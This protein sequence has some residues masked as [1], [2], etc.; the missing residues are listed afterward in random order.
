MTTNL[1]KV[2]DYLLLIDKEAEIKKG[3]YRIMIDKTSILYG[4]FEKH[5]GN[6]EC[7]EQWCK[8]IAYYPLIKGA[9]ELEGLPKLPNPFEEVDIEELAL[10]AY[11]IDS[12]ETLD[13]PPFENV[14]NCI[15]GFIEGYKA[16]QSKGQ[17]SL[18]DMKKAFNA[19]YDLNTWEQLEIP[20][21]ER[22]Y[23]NEDEYIQSLSTQQLPKEFIPEYELGYIHTENGFHIPVV[24]KEPRLKTITNSEGK[25]EIIGKY[26]Y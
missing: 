13:L 24:L 6:H 20:N 5:I 18:E 26:V 8:I 14:K 21:V 16:S 17:Y 7:N 11:F 4:Q 9:K 23:L 15:E 25:E 10:K 2:K 12:M 22:D 3:D 1:I 19:G